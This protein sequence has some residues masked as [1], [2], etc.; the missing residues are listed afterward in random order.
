H[1][2]RFEIDLNRSREKAVYR[3]AEEAWGLEVVRDPP[4]DRA[5]VEGSLEVY[6]AF[7]AELGRRLDVVAERGPFVVFDIHSYNHRRDGAD[8]A[9]APWAENPEVNVGT[10]SLDRSRFGAV[11]D[12]FI[13][14]LAQAGTSAGPLDVRENVRFRGQQ[15]AAWTHQRYPERAIV[16]A[17][18]FKKTFMDEWTAEA[19]QARIDELARA[20]AS[21][22]PSLEEALIEVATP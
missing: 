22:I 11:A 19:D 8:A 15:L 16:L 2:S 21:T 7:Y 10:G 12:T 18:E 4:L 5:L 14:A 3:S 13:E 17:L 1:R 6:D 9:A 20:V